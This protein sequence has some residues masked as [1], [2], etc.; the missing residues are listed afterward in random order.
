MTSCGSDLHGSLDILLPLDIGK[1]GVA[2][3][4]FAYLALRQG[5][6]LIL[7]PQMRNELRHIFHRI[8]AHALGIG[9]LLSVVGRHEQVLYALPRRA[10]R[11]GKRTVYRAHLARKRKLSEKGAVGARLLYRA[12][13]G[14]DT[15]HYRQVVH[16]ACFF[17]V[18]RSEVHGHAADGKLKAVALYGCADAL[19]RLLDGGIGKSHDIEI[20]KSV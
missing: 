11:H 18:R 17:R 10:E 19:P 2:D 13:G 15:E 12:G 8:H 3:I 20:K 6:Y 7:A 4:A 5:L 1:V 16:R 14:K 9:G